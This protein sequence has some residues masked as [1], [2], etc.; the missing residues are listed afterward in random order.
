M[1]SRVPDTMRQAPSDVKWSAQIREE[2]LMFKGN[3]SINGKRPPTVS[4]MTLRAE[5]CRRAWLQI[6]DGTVASD[7]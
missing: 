2:T 6:A 4:R 3:L 7:E 1:I 5:V